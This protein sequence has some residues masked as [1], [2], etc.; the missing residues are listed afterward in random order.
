MADTKSSKKVGGAPD[1]G[2]YDL[3]L[4]GIRKDIES[5]QKEM[6][7][8]NRQI[9]AKSTGKEEFIR[10]K[11]EMK[12]KLDEY[13]EIIDKHDTEKRRIW[14]VIKKQ[15]DQQRQ[16]RN[17]LKDMRKKLPHENL[18]DI[19]KAIAEIEYKM[20]T[21]TL[22][23]KAEKQYLMQIQQLKASKPEIA[24]YA[25]KELN[26]QGD[27]G[28]VGKLKESLNKINAMITEARSAKKVQQ[29]QYKR[30][31]EQ[32]QKAMADMPDLFNQ[33]DALNK[34]IGEKI[35]QRKAVQ[36]VWNQKNREYHAHQAEQRAVKY[37]KQRA[38]RLTRQA[39]N[40]KRKVL[41]QVEADEEQP[42]LAET[43]LIEQVLAYCNG[44]I[45]T[46]QQDVAKEAAD[47]KHVNPEGSLVLASKKQREEEEMFFKGKGKKKDI[48][49]QKAEAKANQKD[50]SKDSKIKHTLASIDIFSSLKLTP[51]VTTADVPPLI[52]QLNEKLA[53]YKEKVKEWENEKE[54]RAKAAEEAL[55]AA[56]AKA[57]ELERQASEALQAAKDRQKA[58]NA[59]NDEKEEKEE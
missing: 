43:T 22:T 34:K 58:L 6:Q 19:D 54:E 14:D 57:E 31:M 24:K 45:A 4:D 28:N 46:K 55:K 35:G 33:R 44:L 49:K 1:K 25:K 42:F 26:S 17:D 37:E 23:L 30:L 32:R 51:P 52:D 2:E 3:A 53:G 18:E 10:R 36:E 20:W 38:E 56:Q 16:A 7:D 11:E 15:Q 47:V 27:D 41:R 29:D 48:R 12:A 5:Y 39:D 9:S 8:L 13:Q 50:D 21:E 40:E 59:A